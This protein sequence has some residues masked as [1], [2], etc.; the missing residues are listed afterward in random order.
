VD[1]LRVPE[2]Q[3]SARA[4]NAL[5]GGYQTAISPLLS[6][7]GVRCRFVPSCSEYARASI[8]N[9]G[10]AAGGLRSAARLARCGPW[11][12]AGTV[13][14]VI[15]TVPSVRP[16]AGARTGTLGARGRATSVPSRGEDAANRRPR[17]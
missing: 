15:A 8:R 3:V 7:A 9:R 17:G 1:L 13:D 10:L 11:T 5:I 12:P 6:R 2:K 4:A 16:M 14:P